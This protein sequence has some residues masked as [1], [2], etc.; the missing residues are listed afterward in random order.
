MVNPWVVGGGGEE[1]RKPSFLIWEWIAWALL[2]SDGELWTEHTVH[3]EISGP[4]SCKTQP[5]CISL[6]WDL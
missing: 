5:V 3:W 2:A 1:E 4:Q 6:F